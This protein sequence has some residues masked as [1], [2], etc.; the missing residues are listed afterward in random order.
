[1]TVLIYLFIGILIG[2]GLTGLVITGWALAA[3]MYEL[4]YRQQ[5]LKGESHG[6]GP[7]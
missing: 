4:W 3:V 5:L 1:M 2:A 7:L 6:D